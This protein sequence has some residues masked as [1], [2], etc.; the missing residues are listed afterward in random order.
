ML[1]AM[2][3]PAA[4][5]LVPLLVV[6]AKPDADALL[7]EAIHY[8]DGE[9]FG[10]ALEKYEAAAAADP[11]NKY[12]A[13][14]AAQAASQLRKEDKCQVPLD[15]IVALVEKA[16]KVDPSRKKQLLKAKSFEAARQSVKVH[17]LGGRSL[18]KKDDIYA[19]LDAIMWFGPSGDGLR[20]PMSRLK[21]GG[22][23]YTHWEKEPNE[24]GGFSEKKTQNYYNLDGTTVII[25]TKKKKYR[26]KI[27]PDGK[28]IV[29]GFG[30]FSDAGG[31]CGA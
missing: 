20:G 19:I 24:E 29:D 15:R 28:L 31:E 25:E 23:I 6:E 8:M 22:E 30:K 26:G 27:T 13:W 2:H 11:K 1:R 14:G 17:L 10:T 9:E 5:L 18:E 16:V 21:I 3:V 4:L 12:A 7:Q